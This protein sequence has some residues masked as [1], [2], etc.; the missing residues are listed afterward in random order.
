L[1]ICR[2]DGVTAGYRRDSPVMSD[3]TI[4]IEAGLTVLS[5]PNGSGKSTVVEL[6]AGSLRPFA[7][8]VS[9]LARPAHD[10]ALRSRRAVCRSS[11]A[12]YPVLSA[13]EHVELL[14]GVRAVDDQRL[15]A[16]IADYQ[17]GK[18]WHVP[19][20]EL[21][22]GNLRKAWIILTTLEPRRLMIFDEP[23]NGL[24]A[25]GIEVFLAELRERCADD[26]A[27]RA[28]VVVAH[29]PPAA[30]AAL[31]ARTVHL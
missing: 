18:W 1:T 29:R 17:L 10:P 7:G 2:L 24:D 4:A 16:R 5:G 22:T 12:L 6:L 3:V 11:P 15:A 8:V 27:G 20:G 19:T 28:V 14:R 26:D 9:V 21:S 23:F 30:L 25:A 31:T 13:A